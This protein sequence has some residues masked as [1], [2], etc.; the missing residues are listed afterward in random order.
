MSLLGTRRFNGR[1]LGSNGTLVLLQNPEM[2]LGPEGRFWSPEAALDP[3]IAFRT[4]R[5][6]EDP[7]VNGEPGG[8]R[9]SI[10]NPEVPLDHEVVFRTLRSFWDPEVDWEPGAASFRGGLPTYPSVRDQAVRSSCIGGGAEPKWARSLMG[11]WPKEHVA[12]M[13]A[14]SLDGH[15]AL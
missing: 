9:R 4:R 7:E 13:E 10:G 14:R 8:T 1:I 2:L 3:E 15:V 12:L 5:L 11:T 6:S